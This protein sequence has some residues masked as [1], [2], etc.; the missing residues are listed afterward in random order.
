[1]FSSCGFAFSRAKDEESESDLSETE[2]RKDSSP[3]LSLSKS[4]N[5]SS[6][7]WQQLLLPFCLLLRFLL[8]NSSLAWIANRSRLSSAF[9]SAGTFRFVPSSFSSTVDVDSWR[10]LFFS[11]DSFG[12]N[13]K[14]LLRSKRFLLR[15]IIREAAD[16]IAGTYRTSLSA[17]RSCDDVRNRPRLVDCK[18]TKQSLRPNCKAS[19]MGRWLRGRRPCV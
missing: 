5:S 11:V 16:A 13:P 4:S 17:V 15:Q 14:H 8:T 10:C 7:T 1:M 18:L 19:S 2:T 12:K 6:V 9:A 3:P